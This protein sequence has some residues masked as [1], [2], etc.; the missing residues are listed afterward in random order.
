[1]IGRPVYLSLPRW[2]HTERRVEHI[3][4][5]PG[6]HIFQSH[7]PLLLWRSRRRG[8]AALIAGMMAP[9]KSWCLVECPAHWEPQ[10]EGVMNTAARFSLS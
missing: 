5:N 6:S 4:T 3:P 1:M 8:S 9:E 2:T 10:E 7:L